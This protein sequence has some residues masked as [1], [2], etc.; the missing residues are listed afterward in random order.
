M[1]TSVKHEFGYLIK[2]LKGKINNKD[3]KGYNSN[4]L[5]ILL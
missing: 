1:L 4:A 5:Q 3:L 2:A